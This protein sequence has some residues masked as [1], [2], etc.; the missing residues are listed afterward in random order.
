MSLFT[1]SNEVTMRT[2]LALRTGMI[3][4]LTS[5]ATGCSFLFVNGPP[6][7]HESMPFFTCTQSNALPI[8]DGIWAGLNGLGAVTALTAEEG[9]YE[10]QSQA[11]G[12][13]IG[14]FVLSSLSA[15]S[16]FKDTRECRAATASLMQRLAPR[17]TEASPAP[18][19]APSVGP[20]PLGLEP[21][22][23]PAA[24]AALRRDQRPVRA[25]GSHLLDVPYRD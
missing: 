3:A 9:T 8:L 17:T 11:V 5:G 16:G 25:N 21:L 4:L 24:P 15:R 13:G 18:S 22:A 2:T 19:T 10:N 6:A 20:S 1:S 12:V 14:W 7:G 23:A